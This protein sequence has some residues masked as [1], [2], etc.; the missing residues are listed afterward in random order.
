MASFYVHILA[1]DHVL[2]RGDC[3]SL[4]LPLPDGLY[5]IQAHHSNMISAVIP[6]LLKCT[7]KDG[8]VINAAV[9]NGLVKVEDNDV[10]VLVE[11]AE[12]SAEIDVIRAK[13]AAEEAEALLRSKHNAMEYRMAQASLIRATNRLRASGRYIPEK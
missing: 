13:R 8:T 10:L 11:S 12:D 3:L 1:E 9:S 5:G 2:V 4:V 6:G 7:M